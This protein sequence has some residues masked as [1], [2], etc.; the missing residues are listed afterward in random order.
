MLAALI[1]ARTR[2]RLDGRGRHERRGGRFAS[3]I[4]KQT[5]ATE[6]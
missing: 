2:L 6:I 4:Y 5:R 3:Y 1:N